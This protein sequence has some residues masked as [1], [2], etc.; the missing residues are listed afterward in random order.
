MD[1]AEQLYKSPP[2]KGKP[3]RALRATSRQLGHNG[4]LGGQQQENLTKGGIKRTIDEAFP[5]YYESG[6]KAKATFN[7]V[8]PV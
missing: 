5:E 7:I 1:T 2:M 6:T 4:D 3:V 8:N